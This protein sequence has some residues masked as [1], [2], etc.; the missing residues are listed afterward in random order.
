MLTEREGIP[1]IF[2]A[3]LRGSPAAATI[4]PVSPNIV[5]EAARKGDEKG[6]DSSGND[7]WH[8]HTSPRLWLHVIIVN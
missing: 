7:A 5:L 8:V 1:H 3:C 2:S 4:S 6:V